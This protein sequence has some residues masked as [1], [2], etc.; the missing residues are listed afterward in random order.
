MVG[1]NL[2]STSSSKREKIRLLSWQ[3]HT[4]K[5]LNDNVRN[6]ILNTTSTAFRFSHFLFLL[7]S[8]NWLFFYNYSSALGLINVLEC[9]KREK[10]WLESL[11]RGND[12]YVF[13]MPGLAFGACF[14]SPLFLSGLNWEEHEE[15]RILNNIDYVTSC[16]SNGND[17]EENFLELL[18]D[19]TQ[20]E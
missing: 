10:R 18:E 16:R 4:H 11:W 2:G 14:V 9:L 17:L 3:L 1:R 12:E 13:Y 19:L 6:V 20:C 7:P 15:N 8:N 5:I